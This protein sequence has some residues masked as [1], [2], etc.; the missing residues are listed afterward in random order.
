MRGR[1]EIGRHARLRIWCREVWGFESLRPHKNKPGE[2]RVFLCPEGRVVYP[3]SVAIRE[4]P[5]PA[6]I[7]N[8]E[9]GW[10]FVSPHFGSAT[11]Q[12][13]QSLRPE[14]NTQGPHSGHIE[15]C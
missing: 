14:Q 1:G 13:W 9:I 5:S 6:Q 3:E 11:L 12:A 10:G 8:S 15:V 7:P 2:S 4:V